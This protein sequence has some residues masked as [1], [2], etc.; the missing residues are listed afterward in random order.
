MSC[1]P[2]TTEEKLWARAQLHLM[3]LLRQ[4]GA[5]F[6]DAFHTAHDAVVKAHREVGERPHRMVEVERL[7]LECGARY[8]PHQCSP[9]RQRCAEAHLS[10]LLELW[11]LEP[12]EALSR[13]RAAV[14]GMID[15]CLGVATLPPQGGGDL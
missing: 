1:K 9:S 4:L 10:R 14:K 7:C 2:L 3:C 12:D 8:G 15:A 13:A 5:S 6:E 11:G